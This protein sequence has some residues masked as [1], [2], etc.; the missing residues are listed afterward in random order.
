[1][2]TER[3]SAEARVEQILREHADGAYRAFQ[4][5]LIPTVDP[6]RVLG[7]RMPDVRRI[8]RSLD[9]DTAR[10]FLAHP[11]HA[12]YDAANVHGVL[13][14]RLKGLDETVAAL[15]AFLPFV[16]NWATC[17]LLNPRA[18]AKP[19]AAAPLKAHVRRW[20]DS[21]REYTVR[22]ALGA[23]MRCYLGDAF[24]PEALEWAAAAVPH[25]E[26]IDKM[27][28]W[29]FA[30]ALAFR[31]GETMPWLEERRLAPRVHAM[32]IQKAVESYRISAEDKAYLRT[33]R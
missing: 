28:A 13:V 7:V 22:F 27:A 23:L 20:L 16:D 2:T 32:A 9:A 10:E 18:F 21:G 14:C 15:D 1:M 24:F 31:R 6:A 30:T 17:D 5:R 19:E 33:L 26:Y 4:C 25:D 11:G 8:A 3:L 29:Y 12:T